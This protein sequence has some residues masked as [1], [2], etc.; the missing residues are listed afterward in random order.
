MV[1]WSRLSPATFEELVGELLT[2]LG[3]TIQRTPVNRDGG[4]DFVASLTA[5]DPFGTEKTETWL[6]EAKLY[7]ESRVSVTSLR[8]LIGALHTHPR[9]TKAV[10]LTNGQLTSAAREFLEDTRWPLKGDLRVVDGTALTSLITQHADL[11]A[12]FFGATSKT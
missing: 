2:Q 5:Q 10:V 4:Y 11:F 3:F 8:Q 6:V 9:A 1:D 12:R 7:K